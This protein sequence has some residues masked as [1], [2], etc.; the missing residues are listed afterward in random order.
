[1]TKV[2]STKADKWKKTYPSAREAERITGISHATIGASARERAVLCFLC[3]F[4]HF[5]ISFM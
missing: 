4:H 1:M 2:S 3:R 5:S